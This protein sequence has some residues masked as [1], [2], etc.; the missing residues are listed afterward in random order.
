MYDINQ[1]ENSSIH[2]DF[3]NENYHD[4]KKNVCLGYTE[5]SLQDIQRKNRLTVQRFDCQINSN[6]IIPFNKKIRH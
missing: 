3:R 1:F 5:S 2:I 4:E 6:I